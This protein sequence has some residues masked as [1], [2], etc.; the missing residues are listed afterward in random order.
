M[1]IFDSATL[2]D[3]HVMVVAQAPASRAS[4]KERVLG[5]CMPAI[6]IAPVEPNGGVNGFSPARAAIS[7]FERYE[8]RTFTESEYPDT[9]KDIQ[10]VRQPVHGRVAYEPLEGQKEVFW[11]YVP[12]TGYEGPD[13]VDLLVQIK[14]QPVRLVYYIQ[15]TKKNLDTTPGEVFCKRP[16]WKISN[17]AAASDT[18]DL[19]ALQRAG[20]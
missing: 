20:K 19:L 1:L 10:V 2:P 16:S 4:T 17:T 9:V 14:G 3:A 11:H 5:I 6:Y 15:I 18:A 8:R 7:Y 12:Q 13:R